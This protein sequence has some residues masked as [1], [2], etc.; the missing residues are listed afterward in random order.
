MVG[1][2]KFIARLALTALVQI[3]VALYMKGG[4]GAS[5]GVLIGGVVGMCGDVAGRERVMFGGGS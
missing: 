5:S 2:A 1:S 3:A 4:A